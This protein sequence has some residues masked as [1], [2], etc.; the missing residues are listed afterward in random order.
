MDELWENCDICCCLLIWSESSTLKM[1][2]IS[3]MVEFGKHHT[4]E[5]AVP[6]TKAA[7]TLLH[8]R[9]V[10][11]MLSLYK[12]T[13]FA[14]F[15]QIVLGCRQYWFWVVVRTGSGLWSGLVLLPGQHWVCAL[16]R[17]GSGL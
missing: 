11:Y 1:C 8:G 9:L 17:P 12:V 6:V 7:S 4:T 2:I 13:L 10:A 15:S 5:M 16:M 3:Y 14:K